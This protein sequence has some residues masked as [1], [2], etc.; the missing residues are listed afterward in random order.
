MRH[1]NLPPNIWLAQA[2]LTEELYTEKQQQI[3]PLQRN[4]TNIR[5]DQKYPGNVSHDMV[6]T[7]NS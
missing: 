2:A 4:V 5:C 3:L 7:A 6:R 1:Y